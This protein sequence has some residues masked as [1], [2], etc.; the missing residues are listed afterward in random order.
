MKHEKQGDKETQ[1]TVVD[2]RGHEYVLTEKIGEGGQGSV[3]RTKNRNILIKLSHPVSSGEHGRWEARIRALMRQPIEPLPIARPLAMITRPRA[4]YVMELMDG[5]EPLQDLMQRTDDAMQTEEK[6]LSGFIE[7]GGLIRRHR[8][9][10]RL[11]RILAEL[12]GKGLAYGD[13]SPANIFISGTMEHSQVWL[14]D[15][16]NITSISVDQGRALYT[17]DYAAPEILKGASGISTST[18]SWSFAVIAYRLLTLNHPFKGDGV[19]DGSP[20][21]E[22]LALKGSLPWVQHPT[23]SSNAVSVGLPAE[24]VLD[25]RLKPLFE[26]CF[27]AGRDNPTGRPRMTEWAEAFEIAIGS[28]TSC[29]ACESSFFWDETRTCP[30]CDHQMDED[31][32]IL[33]TELRYMPPDRILE[34]LDIEI[35]DEQIRNSCWEKTGRQRVVGRRP[36]HVRKTGYSDLDQADDNEFCVMSISDMGLTIKP[37]RDEDVHLQTGG[38]DPVRLRREE[39]LKRQSRSGSRFYLHLGPCHQEHL[40]LSFKW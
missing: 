20:E 34:G 39:I 25:E 13:L 29:D 16:D 23:D 7:T 31:E 38:E 30:F 21:L 6:G 17:P 8:L 5:L 3:Y 33:V 2:D 26:Q 4:G 18:D 9:L 37:S 15:S 22:E 28:C 36:V 27:N 24:L 35:P 32:P 40:V 12:H 19:L 14:I 11:A 10:L 1:K